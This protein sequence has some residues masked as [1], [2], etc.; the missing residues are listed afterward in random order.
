MKNSIKGENIGTPKNDPMTLIRLQ[1]IDSLLKEAEDLEHME[2][3]HNDNG[4]D[5]L[6]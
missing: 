2:T 3:D 6:Q 5:K 1:R 4:E